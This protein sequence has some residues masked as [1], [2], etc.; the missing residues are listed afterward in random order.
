MRRNAFAALVLSGAFV[1]P[2]AAT[3]AHASVASDDLI[4]PG[5]TSLTAC[6]S[7]I[8]GIQLKGF[9]VGSL[10]CKSD[11]G[12][13]AET[14][15]TMWGVYSTESLGTQSNGSEATDEQTT[16]EQSEQTTGEETT[17]EEMTGE[18]MTG[19]QTTGE[20]MTGEQT[21]GTESTGQNIQTP[22]Q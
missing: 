19:E 10:V 12:S 9:S 11:S 2:A 22:S 13:T 6:Q 18:E 1:L 21:T 17:G 16:A 15:G 8:P 7:A 14:P 5:Y 4:K 3:A 20:E